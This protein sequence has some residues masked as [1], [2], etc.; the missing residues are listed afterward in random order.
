MVL[1]KFHGN[2]TAST[3]FEESHVQQ[4]LKSYCVQSHSYCYLPIFSYLL[5]LWCVFTPPHQTNTIAIKTLKYI[6]IPLKVD[7]LQLQMEDKINARS[8]GAAVRTKIWFNPDVS[9]TVAGLPME[10][11][12]NI[13][14]K[15]EQLFR[16]RLDSKAHILQ[17]VWLTG[18]GWHPGL[19]K[20]EFVST[21][22]K[23][24]FF[25]KGIN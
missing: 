15:T 7:S 3:T 9:I 2:W 23:I 16:K 18:R 21:E 6:C 25:T 1:I 24:I 20:V 5:H 19:V 8:D 4:R 17:A 14:A 13:L 11:G 22:D 10:D 12:G